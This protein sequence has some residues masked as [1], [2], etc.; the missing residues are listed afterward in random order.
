MH[1]HDYTGS[2]GKFRLS[3]VCYEESA[4]TGARV[5]QRDHNYLYAYDLSATA[6][7]GSIT[8][9]GFTYVF[10]AQGTAIIDITALS[11]SKL[12]AHSYNVEYKKGGVTDSVT[13]SYFV[14]AGASPYQLAKIAPNDGYMCNNTAARKGYH[15]P[16]VI[17]SAKKFDTATIWQCDLDGALE[18]AEAVSNDEWAILPDTTTIGGVDYPFY[19]NV[20]DTD[21][22]AFALVEWD[23]LAGRSAEGTNYSAIRKRAVWEFLGYKATADATELSTYGNEYKAVKEPKVTIRLR[24]S[25]LDSYGLHYYSDIIAANDVRVILDAEDSLEDDAARVIVTTKDV[26]TNVNGEGAFYSLTVEIAY[27]GYVAY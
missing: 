14:H 3:L 10:D 13:L 7:V 23:A 11:A 17:Y 6:G 2:S 19:I 22:G 27:K 16:N 26:S 25:G 21:K 24:I 20:A 4:T 8:F 1:T 15:F 5:Y 12:G 9:A 18:G